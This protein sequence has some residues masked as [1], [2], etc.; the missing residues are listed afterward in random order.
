[1][2]SCVDSEKEKQ[3]TFSLH[4]MDRIVNENQNGQ[5]SENKK[6]ET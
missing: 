4:S 2:K 6:Q 5:E 1:M 3:M